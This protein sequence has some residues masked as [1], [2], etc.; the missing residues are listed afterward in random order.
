[1]LG[2]KMKR[3]LLL[4]ALLAAAGL[5]YRVIAVPGAPMQLRINDEIIS[6]LKALRAEP[7][8]LDL[9]GTPAAE[10]RDR[11]EPL[12]NS[13]LDRLVSG[14]EANPT[15]AWVLQQM[16]PTVEG[17]HLEDTEARER[18]IAYIE[19]VFNILGIPNDRGTFRKYMIFW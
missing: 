8:F 4:A 12:I 1:M 17:F 16:D 5:G 11:L 6:K 3:R 18:S 7:K 19:K 13:L 15:D 10:E 2:R 14:V 9:P